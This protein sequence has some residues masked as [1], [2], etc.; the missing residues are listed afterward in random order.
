MTVLS[1]K[2]D[3]SM[4]C[5]NRS[6]HFL[7]STQQREMVLQLNGWNKGQVWLYSAH[8]LAADWSSIFVCNTMGDMDSSSRGFV[9]GNW[10]LLHHCILSANMACLQWS[11]KQYLSILPIVPHTKQVAQCDKLPWLSV[12]CW[13]HFQSLVWYSMIKSRVWA[14]FQ[15]EIP[16][17]FGDMRNS[18]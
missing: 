15:Q 13:Q 2:K 17:I 5:K 16:L 3:R 8:V 9:C 18:L 12:N 4:P 6:H 1:G 7:S 11:C 10:N 14:K